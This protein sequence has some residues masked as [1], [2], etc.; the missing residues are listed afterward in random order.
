MV[1]LLERLEECRAA[2]GETD[3]EALKAEIDE[4]IYDLFDLGEEDGL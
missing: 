4:C 1:A 3:I 2:V